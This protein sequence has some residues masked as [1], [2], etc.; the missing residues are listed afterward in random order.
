[1]RISAPNRDALRF[2]AVVDIP[3]GRLPRNQNLLDRSSARDLQQIYGDVG[4]AWLRSSDSLS[5]PQMVSAAADA[6]QREGLLDQVGFVV[7]AVATPD[8]QHQRLLGGYANQRFPSKPDVSAVAEQGAAGPFTALA[9]AGARLES[10]QDRAVVLVLE[11]TALP[12]GR[13]PRPSR[14]SAVAVVLRRSGPGRVIDSLSVERRSARDTPV[15]TPSVVRRVHPAERVAGTTA[16]YGRSVPGVGGLRPAHETVATGVFAL[17]A[18]TWNE[19]A[20]QELI[21]VVEHDQALGYDCSLT[22]DRTLAAGA[23]LSVAQPQAVA[24]S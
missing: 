16:I 7:L 8:S 17:L 3:L 24:S 21:E 1:M 2:E 9:L 15:P 6:L 18:S 20:P 19:T 23:G 11:Q 5:Y 14:D 12:P 4:D 13:T 22:L 10:T